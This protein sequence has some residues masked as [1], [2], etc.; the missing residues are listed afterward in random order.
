MV[1]NPAVP[2]NLI[3]GPFERDGLLDL[4]KILTGPPPA[5]SCTV[6]LDMRSPCRAHVVVM[7][8]PGLPLS[9]G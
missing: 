4:K 7:H 6:Y 1:A 3:Q 2:R 9:D 8:V 5:R